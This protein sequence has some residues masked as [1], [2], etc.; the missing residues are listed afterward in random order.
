M[1][2]VPRL[3]VVIPTLNE[4]KDLPDTLKSLEPLNAEIIVIDSGSKDKTKEIS[5]S[6]GAKFVYHLFQG[7]DSQRNY[8]DTI[9]S[10]EW[11][12]SIE[13]DVVISPDLAREIS[14]AIKNNKVNAYFIPRKNIIWGKIINHTN[15]GP[16]DDCHIWLYR[17]NS[18]RWQ[19]KV[20]EEYIPKNGPVGTLNNYL[21][22]KN[23]E[24][25]SEFID[26]IDKYSE[27]S[28]AN[29]NSTSLIEP[30]VEFFRRYFYKL[31][32]LDGYRGL[33]LSYLQSI[34]Y[35][36]LFVKINTKKR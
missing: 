18:G 15:W 29:H 24:T 6:Y 22:H 26:K 2:A 13:A 30:V 14:E 28:V 35:M 34:Y 36:S 19:G 21:V 25:V 12:L 8:A 31:G 5:M 9:T 1:A 11:I 4:E 17:R 32:F 27:F 7:F 23:Y 16:K 33:F 3:S 10:G 20:H